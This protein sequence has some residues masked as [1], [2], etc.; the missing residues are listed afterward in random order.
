MD[1]YQKIIDEIVGLNPKE[2]SQIVKDNGLIFRIVNTNGVASIVT[3]DYK[4]NRINVQVDN[5]E[6]TK[7]I[8]IG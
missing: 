5:N 1:N 6:V 3:R 2:A 7:V 4:I 8:S